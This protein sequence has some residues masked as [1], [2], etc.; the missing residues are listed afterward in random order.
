M[1]KVK[2][3]SNGI[4][5][6]EFTQF[7][8]TGNYLDYVTLDFS[9]VYEKSRIKNDERSQFKIMLNPEALNILID[10]LLEAKH[11]YLQTVPQA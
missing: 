1:S 4:E 9:S 8:E 2:L 11:D 6:C 3:Q 5:G 10:Q 7:I